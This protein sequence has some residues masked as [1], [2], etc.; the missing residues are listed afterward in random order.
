MTTNDDFQ[1]LQVPKEIENLTRRKVVR[2]LHDG[3]TQTVSALAMRINFARRLMET[4]PDAAD[5]ELEKVED[6]TR[7]ATKEIRHIIFLLRPDEQDP[8]ELFS[9]LELL[10]EKTRSLFNLEIRLDI[11]KELADRLSEDVQRVI[12]ALAEEAID[13]A[14]NRNGSQSLVVSLVQSEDLLAQLKIEDLAESAG[15]GQAFQGV[16]LENIHY[17]ASLIAGSVVVD[18]N[19]KCMQILFPLKHSIDEGDL[20]D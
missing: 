10:A 17:Y 2:H 16:E 19:G 8:F 9:A 13:S 20:Q 7:E 1:D 15:I 11:R 4:D 18:G 12:Y 14:R 6:L 5:I 3:L